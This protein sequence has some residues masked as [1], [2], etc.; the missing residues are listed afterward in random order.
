MWQARLHTGGGL[1]RSTRLVMLLAGVV[2]AAGAGCSS[3][4]VPDIG[5]L[6]LRRVSE[7]QL[8]GGPGRFDYSA[9][10]AARGLLFVAHMGAGQLIEVDVRG[11]TVPTSGYS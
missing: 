3:A 4:Q 6:P 5:G 10:D 9:L 11:H 8:T 2:A 1:V 7:T